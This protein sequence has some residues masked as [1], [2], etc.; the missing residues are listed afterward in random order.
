MI[1]KM[2]G[3]E[4]LSHLAKLLREAVDPK[5][6]V[7]VEILIGGKP[8]QIEATDIALRFPAGDT[9]KEPFVAIIAGR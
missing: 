1:E 4:L 8:Y 6:V 5:K 9:S 7:M 3:E 2:D